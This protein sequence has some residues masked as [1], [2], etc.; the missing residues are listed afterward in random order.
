MRPV[1]AARLLRLTTRGACAARSSDSTCPVNAKCP[2]WLAPNCNSNP[3]LVV[4]RSGGVITPALLMRMSMGLP[5]ALSSSP[6]AATLAN[7][8]RSRFLIV[9]FAF[10]T[11]DGGPSGQIGNGDG[12]LIGG[13]KFDITNRWSDNKSPPV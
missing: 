8:D 6:S 3:S 11:G 7:D 13:Q 5:S 12:V 4:S 9:S 1:R 10:G 2:R